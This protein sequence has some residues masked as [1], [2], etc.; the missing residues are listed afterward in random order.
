[1]P[2]K[3]LLAK[4]KGVCAIVFR[5]KAGNLQFLLLR[6]VLHWKGWEFPKGGCKKGEKPLTTLKREL[7][8]EINLVSFEKIKK[9]SAKLSFWDSIRKKQVQFQAFLVQIPANA[10]VQLKQNRSRE[11]SSFKWVSKVQALKLL[12]FENPKKV[13]KQCLKIFKSKI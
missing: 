6:R 10:K 1:M 4:R 7:R 8:E 2:A 9:I 12:S 3:A 5:K 11:H 13:F